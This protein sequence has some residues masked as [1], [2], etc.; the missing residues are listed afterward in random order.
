MGSSTTLMGLAASPGIAVGRC[1]PVDQRKVKTPKRRIEQEEVQGE[2]GRLRA[3]L[4][5]ADE[6][7][8]TV[9]RKVEELE[10]SEHTAIIDMHRMMLKDEMLLSEV[11]RLVRDDKVNAEWAVKR[12]VRKIKSAFSDIADEYFKE[13]RADVDYV[14]ERII[15]N[16]MGEVVDLEEPPPDGSIVIAHDLSPADTAL[17]LH[18]RKVAAFVTDAGT[19]TSHTAIVARALEIPAV[20]GVGRI[21]ALAD[22]GAWIIVDGQRGIVVLNPSP[23]ERSDYD[24]ARERW[25]AHERE[26][27]ATRDLPATTVDGVS[28]RLA[29]NIEF[30]EEVKSLL[31]HGGE[32]VGLYRTEFLYM[33][34]TDLPDEEEHYRN[35]RQVLEALAPRPV[36]IRTFDLGG[37][38][39]PTGARS[40]DENPALGLRALRYCLR[41]PDMFRLQLRG[42]LRASVH[43]NLRVMFPMV[44]GLGELRAAKRA[45]MESREELRRE[46]IETRMP[47]VGI[48]VELPSAAVIA[49]RLAK[50]C[51]FLS[52]GTNDLIQY[53]MAIDR[54]NKDVAYLYR[55][56]HLAV[57][58][59]L[60]FICEAGQAAGIPVSMCGEMAG[61]P[62]NV[63]VLLGLGLSELSMI[64]ASVP[65]VKRVLRA[66]SAADGKRLLERLLELSAASDIER[67]VRAEMARKFPGLL[68][69]GARASP[70]TG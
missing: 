31:D 54:Q 66:A 32:G 43:G 63:L 2:L 53:T 35:Y 58:R 17:L 64:S 57:L 8:A 59:M 30:A 39:L 15:K 16:L 61:D 5:A 52:I 13:R 42:L 69:N 26:L 28:V 37:D 9:R 48:M 1:W 21:S 40:H 55:P 68:E 18:E 29:G 25:L 33:G 10:G 23:Q 38:K 11:R 14:G 22:K 47:P 19:K 50:E 41:H 4:E 62:L 44:S 46:G 70:I 3:A 34:R 67:E 45:F 12:A 56:L 60:K 7:L 6:Q 49:D 24:D 20:V 65:L 51:E 27:M 36:T